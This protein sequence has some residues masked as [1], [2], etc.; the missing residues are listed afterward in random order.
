MASP[1]RFYG[2]SKVTAGHAVRLAEVT[3]GTSNTMLVVE[4]ADKPNRWRA[5]SLH[6]DRTSD[7]TA[8]PIVEGFSFG[9]W[10]APNWNHLRAYTPDGKESFGNCAVN[11]S[12]A[13]SIYS[14]H[15]GYANV[16]MVDGSVRRVR[17]GLDEVLLVALVS[18]AD[19]EFLS[20]ADYLAQ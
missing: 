13:G 14:F 17:A 11:C 20:E 4:M 10:I 8:R 1:G 12:N 9:Q 2:G 5:G 7:T 15:P 18:I 6:D 16:L 19:G 3:D